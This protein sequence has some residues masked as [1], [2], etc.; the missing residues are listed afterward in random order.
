MSRAMLRTYNPQV[1]V[2]QSFYSHQPWPETMEV[3][4][5]EGMPE[6]ECR[7]VF[8][9]NLHDSTYVDAAGTLAKVKAYRGHIVI[10]VLPAGGSFYVYMLDD[11][12]LQQ[13]VKSI[14]GPYKCN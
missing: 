8:L 7:D 11:N 10:R 13:R 2:N 3:T 9:T 4:L 12:D 14:H 6:G 5:H 1:V